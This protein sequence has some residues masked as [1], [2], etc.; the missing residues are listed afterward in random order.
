VIA[1]VLRALVVPL[2][3]AM[4]LVGCRER[5]SEHV[6]PGLPP[7]IDVTIGVG[8]GADPWS[9][10]PAGDGD[11]PGL[12]ERNRLADE[13]CPRVTAP[14]FYR[15]AKRGKV[16]HVLGTRHLGVSL[17]KFP[18]VVHDTLRGARRV[19][20]E[21]SPHDRSS[22]DH[23]ALP[24]RDELGP[25]L[26][27]RLVA[28]VGAHQAERFAHAPPSSALLS[29][30]VLYEDV[31]AMLDSEIERM[32]LEA[33]IPAGGL[34]SSAFQDRLLEELLDLRM[35]RATL[36]ATTDRARLAAETRRDLAEYCS[37]SDD[38]PG[39]DDEARADLL[40]AGYTAAELD[41]LDERLVFARNEAWIP[42]LDR[43]FATGDVVVVVG[44]DHLTGERGVVRLLEARGYQ[45]SRVAP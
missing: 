8:P 28:L 26:W 14:Y 25:E 3:L 21:V 15:V 20:F 4:L 12:V 9:V 7:I 2:A 36:T 30:V 18:P 37:G 16:S 38:T 22:H 34:E 11:P 19:V 13:A 41:E 43:L 10:A 42:E 23:A 6:E 17:A 32:V 33:G 39:L 35:L 27:Q 40:A 24:L 31:T 29:L 44:A 5:R 1:S 45:V